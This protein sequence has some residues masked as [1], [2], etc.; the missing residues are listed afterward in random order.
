MSATLAPAIDMNK[1]NQPQDNLN[2]VGRVCYSFSTLLHMPCSQ[3][4]DVGLC[5][6]ARP[7][8]SAFGRL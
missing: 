2:P 6:G 3:S 1:L 4:Q 5:L 7:E 8:R